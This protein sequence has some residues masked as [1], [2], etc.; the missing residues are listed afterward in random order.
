MNSAEAS[1]S[2]SPWTLLKWLDEKK[3]T[4]EVVIVFPDAHVR[5]AY[6]HEIAGSR[7]GA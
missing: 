3:K 1:N 5:W 7:A 2:F 6:D 4:N